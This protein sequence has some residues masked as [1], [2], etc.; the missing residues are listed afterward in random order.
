MVD[1]KDIGNYIVYSDGR[2]W[3][4]RKNIF[5]KTKPNNGN[6]YVKLVLDNKKHYL[7]RLVAKCFIPNPENKPNVHHID[8]DQSN[9]SMYNLK[10]VTQSENVKESYNMGNASQ[11]GSK[12]ASSKL[13]EKDVLEIRKSKLPNTQLAKIYKVHRHTISYVKNRK[14]WTHI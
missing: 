7:H 5:M 2:V 9:N 13:T 8:N 12:N 3:S 14:F 11:I 4:K 6:G 10:W 1:S